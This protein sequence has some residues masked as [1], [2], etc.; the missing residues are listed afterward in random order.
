MI[1]IDS[2]YYIARLLV[3]DKY[4]RRAKEIEN[5]LNEKKIINSTVLT[6]TLNAFTR[7]G[8]KSVKDLFNVLTEM[9]EVVYLS[10][11]DYQEAADIFNYYDSS[12]NYSDCTVLQSM[13]NL[14]ITKIV[15]F[16]EDFSKIRGLSVIK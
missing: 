1:F 12:I 10:P 4:H 5:H 6:E 3:D 11:S 7:C 14:G 16:D 9:N 2:S 8:G 13:Q 15:S